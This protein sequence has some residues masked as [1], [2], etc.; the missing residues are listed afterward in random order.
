[1]RFSPEDGVAALPGTCVDGVLIGLF[2]FVATIMVFL[3]SLCAGLY[4]SS[5]PTFLKS[6]LIK[7][8]KSWRID[9]GSLVEPRNHGFR[10]DRSHKQVKQAQMKPTILP[11][12]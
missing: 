10:L 3:F 1:M 2:G 6:T 5:A 7:T 8:N 12:L 9:R 11:S 4:Y